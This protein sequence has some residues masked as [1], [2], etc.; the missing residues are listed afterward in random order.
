MQAEVHL[1]NKFVIG[2]WILRKHS[3][4][5]AK[6]TGKKQR[7]FYRRKLGRVDVLGA[8]QKSISSR[9]AEFGRYGGRGFITNP[10]SVTEWNLT[11]FSIIFYKVSS[12][13]NVK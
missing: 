1:P 6:M 3:I 11:M 5:Q 13:D 4:N 7:S 10:L 9:I 12:L 2:T 8:V